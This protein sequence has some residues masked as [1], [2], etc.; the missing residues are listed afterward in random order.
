MGPSTAKPRSRVRFHL[1]ELYGHYVALVC[2][3]PAFAAAVLAVACL[4]AL[5][6]SIAFFGHIEAGLQELLP[7]TAP[8]VRALNRLHALVGGKS[9]L[10]II[11]RSPD[12][13]ANERFISELAKFG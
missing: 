6:L 11:A 1:G 8:S 7:P 4:P 10:A 9:H 12:R 3:R 5:L 13:V 2:A